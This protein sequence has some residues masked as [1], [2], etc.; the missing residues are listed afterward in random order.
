[1]VPLARL[2]FWQKAAQPDFARILSFVTAKSKAHVGFTVAGQHASTAR[3]LDCY[4]SLCLGPDSSRVGPP[5]RGICAEIGQAPKSSF[6]N[7]AETADSRATIT[8]QRGSSSCTN[9]WRHSPFFPHLPLLAAMASRSIQTVQH[10]AL[11]VARPSGLPRTT[12]WHKAL[13]RAASWALSRAT[14]AIAGK[15]VSAAASRVSLTVKAIRALPRVAF[16]FVMV[17]PEGCALG[18]GY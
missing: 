8:L 11:S 12:T 10:L 14:K 4:P 16:L 5:F 1:M 17:P 9:P 15:T 7:P 18:E 2:A 3:R 6:A 13:S